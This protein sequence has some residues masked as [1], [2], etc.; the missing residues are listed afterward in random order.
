MENLNSTTAS[1]ADVSALRKSTALIVGVGT[2]VVWLFLSWLLSPKID[3]NEPPVVKP[4]IPLIGHI[5]DMIYY[6]SDFLKRI[7]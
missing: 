2:T 1:V 5:I 3:P 7:Q 6:K 4:R